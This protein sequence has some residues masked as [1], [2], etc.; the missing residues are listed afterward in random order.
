MSQSTLSLAE[1]LTLVAVD[2]TSGAVR[3]DNLDLGLSGALLVQLALAGRIDVVD[4]SVVVTDPTPTGDP[5]PDE[6]LAR[7]GADKPRKPDYWVS[8]LQK[9][10]RQQVLDRLVDAGV[11]ERHDS[12]VLGLFPRHRY[13]ERNAGP[14]T[15]VRARLDDAVLH[16]QAPD[17]TT[18]A[19]VGLLHAVGLR[20]AAF[21]GAERKP[22]EA[23][24]KLIAEGSWASK[25][26]RDAVAQVQAAVTAGAMAATTAAVISST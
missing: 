5:L 14:E 1:Q 21:P 16:G 17:E 23:R 20:A 11:L 2:D 4:S 12:K 8:H 22:T 3:G 26:V 24:M 19:L 6:A 10:V 18:S 15:A 7:I 9:G 13:P 25:A